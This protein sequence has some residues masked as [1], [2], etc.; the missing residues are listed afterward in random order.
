MAET[1]EIIA[2]AGA[3]GA[4]L[5]ALAAALGLK[6]PESKPPSE[7]GNMAELYRR[8]N[9]IEQRQSASD[10]RIEFATEIFED[11][12][13]QLTEVKKQIGEMN[14]NITKALTQLEERRRR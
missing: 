4:F 9:E 2:G 13:H 6:R 14:T 11:V 3:V 1:G 8:L 10:V 12:K 5:G 7:D